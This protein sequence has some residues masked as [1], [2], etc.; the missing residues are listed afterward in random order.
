MRSAILQK[1][2]MSVPYLGVLIVF[3][4]LFSSCDIMLPWTNVHNPGTENPADPRLIDV[5]RETFTLAWD[6]IQSADAYK[7][8]YRNHGESA[9]I[10]LDEISAVSGPEFAIN[11]GILSYGTYEFAVSTVIDGV[12]SDLHTSLD[13]TADP[14]SGW[15]IN[16]TAPV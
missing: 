11:T 6:P 1:K 2:G 13:E 16:W 7:L 9:W 14:S 4:T 10:E 8:Y 3:I 15:F 12:E 5:Q